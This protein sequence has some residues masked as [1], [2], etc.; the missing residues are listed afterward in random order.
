MTSKTRSVQYYQPFYDVPSGD[1]VSVMVYDRTSGWETG[2]D[3]KSPRYYYTILRICEILS[4]PRAPLGVDD[5]VLVDFDSPTRHQAYSRAYGEF[6]EKMKSSSGWAT[7]LAEMNQSIDSLSLRFKQLAQFTRAVRRLDP[8]AA[9]KA[10]GLSKENWLPRRRNMKDA[11]GLWL[12]YHFGWEPLV[13]DIGDAITVLGERKFPTLVKGRGN[14]DRNVSNDVNDFQK[15]ILDRWTEN[16]FVHVQATVSVTDP[17][18]SQLNQLGFVNPLSV[19]WDL[20]P[21]SFVVDWFSNIGQ[22]LEAATD[23]VGFGVKD[24]FV[25]DYGYTKRIYSWNYKFDSLVIYNRSSETTE[26]RTLRRPG[27][28]PI[29]D[30]I[31]KPFHGFSVSR[32]ATSCSLLLQQLSHVK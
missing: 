20:V 16:Y 10:L 19:A 2:K 21:F 22:I 4:G 9:G 13:K 30:L 27:A 15:H 6:V 3:H 1:V 7:N 32:A 17:L 31:V 18:L 23:F 12:E 29:P 26:M 24:A 28:I 11:S 8:V 25:T 14:S 5:S